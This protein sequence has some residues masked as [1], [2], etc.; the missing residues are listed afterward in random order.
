MLMLVFVAVVVT[1]ATFG[2]VIVIVV[3]A[4]SNLRYL[5]RGHE[6]GASNSGVGKN[7]AKYRRSNSEANQSS[8][9]N[10]TKVYR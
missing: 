10:R 5:V 6:T 1:V 9:P 4:S 7:V 3:L 8:A 2:V